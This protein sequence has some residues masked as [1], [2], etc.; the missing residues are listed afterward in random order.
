M[1]HRLLYFGTLATLAGA[2]LMAAS[3]PSAAADVQ[4]QK[5]IPY[6][7]SDRMQKLDAYLPSAAKFPGPRP[8][9][10]WIHG[11][12]WSDGSKA[13]GREQRICRTLAENGYAAFSIDYLLTKHLSKPTEA[14][15][16]SSATQGNSKEATEETGDD[17]AGDLRVPWPQ[18]LYD[19]KTAVRFIRKEAARFNIDPNRIAVSGG[20]AGGHLALMVGLTGNVPELNKGGLYT[21]QSN[22]VSCIIDFYGPTEVTA[23]KRAK[24]FAGKTPEETA[25]NLRTASPLTHVTKDSPP[26]LIAH[27]TKDGTCD[28]DHSRN[29]D[30]AMTAAGAVHQYIE[31]PGGP[32][33]FDLQPKQMDLRPAVLEFLAKYLGSPSTTTKP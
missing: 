1:N 10:I 20:S 26:T 27:G 30:K 9:V 23:G 32:H 33:S 17:D 7:G 22:N 14:A 11:G 16:S 25:A 29:L 13:A 8:V 4:V 18:N 24:K 5:D 2:V 3:A 21:E 6:L 12:G 31:V 28:I 19:C 15:P